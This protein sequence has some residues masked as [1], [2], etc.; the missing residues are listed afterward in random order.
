MSQLSAEHISLSFRRKG[1]NNPVLDNISLQINKGSSVVLLGPSGCG[2][3][4]LL[5]ILAGFQEPGQG[6]VRL[7]HKILNAPSGERAVV[8]QDD[9]LLP[10]LNVLEN[11]A[12]GL[13]ING[14]GKS[15]R[16]AKAQHFLTLVGL[17]NYANH[18]VH[19]LS[20]GQ[21]QRVGLA[22]ALAIEPDFILLDEPF[23][24]LD[25]L[26]REKMQ[27][28]L[29]EIWKQTEVGIFLI[30]HSVDEGLLLATELYVLK[31]P[32]VKV[33]HHTF[34]GYAQRF[35]AGEAVSQLKT[36]SGF[37]KQRQQL[38]DYLLGEEL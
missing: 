3:S 17:K 27:G 24:A 2:K 6:Q 30:T 37:A 14:I 22:R 1:H 12:I 5:N 32:P 25:A 38:L 36:E 18:H 21:R 11:V 19:E 9:A 31:G 13:R 7:N 20:G 15:E 23:G 28:L 33:V 10:W 16:Q 8:F 34:P 29:L 35:L 26:T 4:T